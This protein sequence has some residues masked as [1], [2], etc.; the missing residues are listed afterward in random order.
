MHHGPMLLTWMTGY[1]GER[2]AGHGNR[3]HQRRKTSGLKKRSHYALCLQRQARQAI[4]S[5]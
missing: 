3:K 1:L 4:W 5:Q 2:G